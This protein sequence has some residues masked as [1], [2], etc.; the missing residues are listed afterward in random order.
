MSHLSMEE[1]ARTSKETICLPVW[2]SWGT[3]VS[4]SEFDA[5]TR[6]EQLLGVSKA[7]ICK[8]H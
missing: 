3:P 7:L 8:K 2:C 5:Y 6:L 4:W 1:Q